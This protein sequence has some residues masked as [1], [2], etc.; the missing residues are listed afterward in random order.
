MAFA[1]LG[2]SLTPPA[3]RGGKGRRAAGPRGGARR[4]DVGGLAASVV[5]LTRGRR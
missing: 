3:R 4:V 2:V 5:R 1:A